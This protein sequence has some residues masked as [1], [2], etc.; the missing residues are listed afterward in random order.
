M[1]ARED[2]FVDILRKECKTEMREIEK[3]EMRNMERNE[4]GK[5]IMLRERERER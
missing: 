5:A 4:Q 3:N 2:A 1:G